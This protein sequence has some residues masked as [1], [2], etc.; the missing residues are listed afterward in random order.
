MLTFELVST[1]YN[2][3]LYCILDPGEVPNI[4]EVSQTLKGSRLSWLAVILPLIS[5]TAVSSYTLHFFLFFCDCIALFLVVIFI[6]G[7]VD[8]PSSM[9]FAYAFWYLLGSFGRRALLGIGPS[10][11]TERENTR[12]TTLSGVSRLPDAFSLSF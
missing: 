2:G 11:I 3:I 1:A 12:F 6:I 9:I 7:L 5:Y 8:D 10:L 4:L